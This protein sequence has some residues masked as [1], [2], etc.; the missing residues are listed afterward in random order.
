MVNNL[1]SRNNRQGI[2]ALLKK[3]L[4]FLCFALIMLLNLVYMTI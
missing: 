2:N 3:L 1:L 4:Y